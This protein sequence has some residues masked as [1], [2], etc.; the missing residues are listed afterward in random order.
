MTTV[1]L[2]YRYIIVKSQMHASVEAFNPKFGTYYLDKKI[3]YG[4]FGRS[5]RRNKGE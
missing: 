2:S 5:Q 4:G 1:A 3:T